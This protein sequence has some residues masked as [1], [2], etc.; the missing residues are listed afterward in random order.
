MAVEAK[1]P[2]EKK[3]P[4]AVETPL[5]GDQTRPK[6]VQNDRL[7]RIARIALR[8]VLAILL[9]VSL[10][11]NGATLTML[12]S[13]DDSVAKPPSPEV[14]MGHFSFASSQAEPG[15]VVNASFTIHVALSE[16]LEDEGRRRIEQRQFRLQQDM[17]ELLRGAHSG[18]F[19]DPLLRGLK[20][21]LKDRVEKTL[22]IRA[23]AYVVITGLKTGR[24]EIA[25]FEE[26]EP[27]TLVPWAEPAAK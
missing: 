17:E 6:T 15:Q 19:D 22:G 1:A 20:G 2:P 27:A 7:V 14:P 3:Q 11:V 24:T 18:D 9:A 4:E 5:A 13:Q 16:E 10:L 23:V 8:N 26:L 12:G 21:K 25:P